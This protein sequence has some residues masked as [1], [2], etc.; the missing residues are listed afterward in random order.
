[1]ESSD[2]IFNV[3]VTLYEELAWDFLGA[4]VGVIFTGT[5]EFPKITNIDPS[6]SYFIVFSIQNIIRPG[7]V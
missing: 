1:M 4:G 3:S 5:D 2:P 6:E 7:K